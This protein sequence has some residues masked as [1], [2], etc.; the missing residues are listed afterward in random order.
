MWMR[1][2]CPYFVCGKDSD[3][4]FVDK[5]PNV[6]SEWKLVYVRVLDRFDDV[7]YNRCIWLHDRRKKMI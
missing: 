3:E 5:T 4:I 2:G 1:L 6:P 7:D